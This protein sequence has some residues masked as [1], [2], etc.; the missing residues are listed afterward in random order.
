MLKLRVLV[1]DDSPVI[2]EMVK[3]TFIPEGFEVLEAANGEDALKIAWEKHPDLII[4]DIKMPGIDGWEVCSQI[5]KHPYTSFIP[6]IFLT[7]KREVSD[8]IRGL[9]MGA[10]DYITK[11]FEPEELVAR[12]R[13]IFNRMLKR[14]E[15]KIIQSRGLRGSTQMMELSDL[16]QLFGIN[17]KTGILKVT[18][19]HGM[20]GRIGFVA[21]RLTNAEL[22]GA[23]G[24]KAIRRMLRWEEANFQVEPLL[25]E[26]NDME[27]SGKIEEV[28]MSAKQEQDEIAVLKKQLKPET[29][30]EPVTASPAPKELSPTEARVLAGLKAKGKTRV[31]EILDWLPEF[32]TE[33]YKAVISLLNRNLVRK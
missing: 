15:E 14:E 23:R 8:R 7:E 20:V 19:P 5:R 22:G 12:A 31:E 32:D 17:S 9:E 33:I 16:L 27:I 29:I 13:A 3:D 26:K 28:I 21:G 6:F 10:D 25:D 1:I 30:I 2:R 18:H 4:A 11:P 24:V